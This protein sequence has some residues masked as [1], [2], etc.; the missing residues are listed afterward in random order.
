MELKP[1]KEKWKGIWFGQ[2]VF[3]GTLWGGEFSSRRVQSEVIW[4][5]CQRAVVLQLFQKHQNHPESL[6]KQRLLGPTFKSPWIQEVWHGTWSCA[7][8][9]SDQAMLML[10]AQDHTLNTTAVE[11][12]QKW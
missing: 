3:K 12:I 1:I 10:L 6:L 8:L 4:Q 5:G 11:G 7:F 9:T 2:E